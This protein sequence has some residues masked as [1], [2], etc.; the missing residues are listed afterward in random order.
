MDQ[1]LV[2]HYRFI[3]QQGR[4]ELVEVKINKNTMESVWEGASPYPDWCKLEFQQCSNCPLSVV[5]H[6][7]CPL[8]IQLQKLLPAS[9]QVSS[10]DEVDMEA[11]TP[12]RVVSKHTT[13]QR[14]ISSLM[15]LMMA[16]SG[17][18][19]MAFLK[20]MARFH[21]PLATEEET[22]FR[23]VS[24]YLLAQYFRQKQGLSTDF[25]LNRLKSKYAEISVVN[26]SMAARLRSVSQEDSAINAV[27]LLDVFAKILPYSI[28]ESLE[29]IR[30]LFLQ[31]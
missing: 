13:V 23:S 11:T 3:F 15:G 28:D 14:A 6:P 24:A 20:P 21:L 16:T 7:S 31:H 12:E 25:E 29:E 1:H 17:C 2:I 5:T 19:H 27:V 10:Y 30:Y 4:E 9:H 18:P 26:M 22:L 8:A